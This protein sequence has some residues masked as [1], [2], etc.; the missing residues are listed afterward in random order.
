MISGTDR[1]TLSAGEIATARY[2]AQDR[3]MTFAS[4]V[5]LLLARSGCSG[6]AA[7]ALLRCSIRLARRAEC[8]RPQKIVDTPLVN[9]QEDRASIS[10]PQR[11]MQRVTTH[12]A[13][14]RPLAATLVAGAGILV[15]VTLGIL[16]RTLYPTWSAANLDSEGSAATWF[17]AGLLWAAAIS[18]F[19]VAFAERPRRTVVFV[20]SGVIGLLAL[21][22][23]NAF[24]EALERSSGIDWQILYLPVLVLAGLV[25]WRIMRGF[26]KTPIATLLVGGA[27]A[28]G[29]VLVLELVQNWGGPPVRAEIYDPTMITE[30]GLEMVGST[31]TFLAGLAALR[32]LHSV[33]V[34]KN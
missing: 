31:L 23:A 32:A 11:L 5:A 15:F 18:W 9:Q 26:E 27:T 21:D 12:A 17:A 14:I 34:V 3:S 25:W 6:A 33:G 8:G 16:Q 19:L 2:V 1:M 7:A 4:S 28:W 10:S 20:W 29:V 13:S 30:E 24:H 22:E